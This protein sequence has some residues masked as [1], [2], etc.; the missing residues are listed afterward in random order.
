MIESKV[1]LNLIK[2]YSL[3]KLVKKHVNLKNKNK[4]VVS[5]SC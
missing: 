4:T 3:V 2:I 1:N 5:N